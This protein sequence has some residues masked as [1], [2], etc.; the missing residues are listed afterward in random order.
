LRQQPEGVE[1]TRPKTGRKSKKT[2]IAPLAFT[3]EEMEKLERKQVQPGQIG[4]MVTL[5]AFSHC[6][7]D[8]DI[9]PITIG[10]LLTTS[11]TKG[12]AQKVLDPAKAVGSII[13]K[14]LGSLNKGKGKIPANGDA[15]IR[16]VWRW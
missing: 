12:H 3:P 14:A 13:G 7:V 5:G 11:A 6:K 8:A 15:A 9:A 4:L 16:I 2:V 10:D 1:D